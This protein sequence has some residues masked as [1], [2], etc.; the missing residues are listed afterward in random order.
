MA[1]TLKDV[2]TVTA[3]AYAVAGGYVGTKEEFEE[4]LA[5][6]SITVQE[7]ENL[8][9]VA[10]T[11]TPGSEATASY[12]D[13]VLTFGIPQ[14]AKGETG[15]TGP[16]G[17][18]GPTGN[19]IVSITKTGTS[20]LVDTYTITFTDGTTTT[21]A[22]TNGADGDITNVAQAFDATKAYS[23]GDMVLY[24]GT[25]YAFTAVHAAGAWVGSDA[26]AVI[27][28]D[29]VTEL[30][31]DFNGIS[32]RKSTDNIFDPSYLVSSAGWTK[33]GEDY[34][35]TAKQ[36]ADAF[37]TS[38]YY[39]VSCDP[40]KRYVL[41]F[42]AM[43]TNEGNAP[44][45]GLVIVFVYGDGATNQ[46]GLP[47]NTNEYTTFTLVSSD[48]TAQHGGI[49]AI[50]FG[51][52]N[53]GV[54][55]WHMKEIILNEGTTPIDYYGEL[56]AV[57][58]D[59][60]EGLS[61]L[62]DDFTEKTSNVRMPVINFQFDDGVAKDADIVSIFDNYDFKCGFAVP[63]NVVDLFP[64][65]TYQGKGY[66]VISHSTDGTG[67]NDASVDSSVIE[68]KLKT[69]KETLEN[70][71]LKIRGFV[72][73]NSIMNLKFR[74]LLRKYYDWADTISYGTYAGTING[75]LQP[76]MAPVDGVYNGWRVSLQTT[77]LANAKLA[78]DKCIENYGCLTFYGHAWALDTDNNLT[79]ANLTSLLDYIADKVDAGECACDIPSKAILNY[80]NVRNDDV[81]DGWISVSPT[82]A[83]LDSRLSVVGWDMRY[84]PKTKIF[85]FSARLTA[86][87][88]ISGS[89]ALCKIPVHLVTNAFGSLIANESGKN[90]LFYNNG[91]LCQTSTWASGTSYR[92][93]GFGIFD[94][95]L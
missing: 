86:T 70:A 83:E 27:L 16:Q 92:M 66:E 78:V 25:L 20:G 12:S 33:D 91:V 8:T 29:E 90:M 32:E 1:N 39:P 6:A 79:T 26:Q 46:I 61:V 57:D 64:Y 37:G 15:Q 80:F 13:G 21:F 17:P 47:N 4:A 93:S 49:T 75:S 18:E 7:L 9:A 84:N 53:G 3:Y 42:K 60:R 35:G 23:V 34:Y 74:P 68:A 87:E 10:V 73:P 5:N 89:F 52:S 81:S 67:M 95:V 69:S 54:N 41:S 82:D 44:G 48:S 63:T 50:K 88:A 72:T 77:T 62:Q 71:G 31:S 58:K 30:K 40:N 94:Y 55:V 38:P 24:Q 59:A 11:L 45:N 36:A 28:A 56:T 65:V 85:A 14:G 76:Y 51:Y 19:G 2:G 22:V 43:T